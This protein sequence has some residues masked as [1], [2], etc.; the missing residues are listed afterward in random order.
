MWSCALVLFFQTSDDKAWTS[1]T[2]QYNFI[3]TKEEF[4]D[5]DPNYIGKV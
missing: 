5:I 3:V 4:H 2:V 1:E